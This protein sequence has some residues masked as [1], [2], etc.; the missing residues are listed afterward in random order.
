MK[1]IEPQPVEVPESI[2][3][4]ISMEGNLGA[5]VAGLL[6]RRG[7]TDADIARGFLDPGS[8]HP[9]PPE[10]LPDLIPAVDRLAEAIALREPIAV[11][12]DFDVD[13]QTATAL[14]VEALRDLGASVSFHIPTRRESH[15]LHPEG[16]H[17]LVREGSRL[18]LTADTGVD[19]RAAVDLAADHGVGVL[20]TDHHD[21]PETLPNAL[22]VVNPKRLPSGHPLG[23]LPGVGVAYQVVRSL[24]ERMGRTDTDRFLDLVALGVVADVATVVGDVR[25]LLQRG[26]AVLQ[27]TGRPGLKAV[28]A[29]S[30]LNPDLLTEE[31]IGFSLAPRLNALS[32]VG[33]SE[34]GQGAMGA[35]TGVELLTT[36]DLIR[37]RTIAT[38]L[39]ALNARRKWLTRQTTDAALSQLEEN[40]S[41]LDGPAIVVHGERW[42]PGIVGI[43]AGRLAEQFN[44]PA[45]VLSA[46]SG[47]M[48]RGSA[49]SV[50]GIDIH[51]AIAAQRHMLHRC[52][53]HP[54]AAGLSLESE[55]IGEFRRALWR[56]LAQ[57]GLPSADRQLGIDAQLSLGQLT[58]DLVG[59]VNQLAPFGPGNERP[60]FVSRH[61]Q[62]LSSAAIGRTREHRRVVVRDSDQREQTVLWWRSS[63]QEIP[64][65]PFD[66]AYTV[67]INTFRGQ[68]GVQ[69]TWIE[70]RSI[71]PPAPRISVRPEIVI[72]DYR[73]LADGIP[74]LA[75][76]T[77]SGGGEGEAHVVVWAEG[78][79]DDLPSHVPPEMI[80]D[81]TS[82]YP[83][84]LLIVWTA[85]PGPA[86][87]RGAMEAISPR[88]VALFG[89]DPGVDA[90]HAFLER[91]AGL[92]KYALG[93]RGGRVSLSEL[94]VT[95]A[96]S[97]ETVELGLDWL[98]QKG[99]LV[100]SLDESGRLALLPGGGQVGD[101]VHVVQG[102]LQALLE[103]TAAYRSYFR[104]ADA[105]RL[106]RAEEER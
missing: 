37:A 88:E 106:L 36:H 32:R 48:A 11:W 85:P 43:V 35:E 46:P 103:E 60:V 77:A 19:A 24:Y 79:G 23:E 105:R 61:L 4:V 12:G 101:R 64:E 34:P 96:H 17:R 76:L 56:T 67:G 47:E 14:Y 22:V 20:I 73:D 21:L 87:L 38:A 99:Q 75:S 44:K 29:L 42:D 41:L 86:E 94:A 27:T 31:D 69:L 71:A 7:I 82:L 49:R 50:E 52:G 78:A 51:A 16:V 72:R 74:V 28:M 80:R 93:R 66:L 10:V 40:R 81:R 13:G 45:V 68:A 62:A 65:S 83:A 39:E 55:R 5:L 90:P 102:Q 59:A 26:L 95:M 54:M 15:G 58:L 30:D 2:R 3:Q 70:A 33:A 98:A 1:W 25:Y 57:T 92:C 104:R 53:G 89:I 91:L 8:Y 18:I 63:G 97:E 9:A 6:V 84:D 100:Y